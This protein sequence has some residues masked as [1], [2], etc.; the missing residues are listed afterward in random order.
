MEI[1]KWYTSINQEVKTI[2]IDF[3]MF[4]VS[5]S[6]SQ[7]YQRGI[8]KKIATSIMP[9]N[10]TVQQYTILKH[11][12]VSIDSVFSGDANLRVTCPDNLEDCRHLKG[13]LD[14]PTINEIR[15]KDL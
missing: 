13:G 11:I 7:L 14:S 1:T 9:I 8:P 2:C 15:R 3:I 6:G 10:Q 12:V 5:I 4:L